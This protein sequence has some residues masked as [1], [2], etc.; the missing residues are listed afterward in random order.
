MQ[1]QRSLQ[2]TSGDEASYLRDVGPDGKHTV[3]ESHAAQACGQD[4]VLLL[5]G[6]SQWFSHPEA[7]LPEGD[8][9]R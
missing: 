6:P 8:A 3:R 7:L 1:S 2:D 5:Q 9:G 4:F